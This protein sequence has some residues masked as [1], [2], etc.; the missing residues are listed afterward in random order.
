M[1]AIYLWLL[2]EQVYMPPTYHR[3]HFDFRRRRNEIVQLVGDGDDALPI[4]QDLRVSRLIA[5]QGGSFSYRLVRHRTVPMSSCV[6]DRSAAEVPSSAVVT[7]GI[8]AA[9]SISVEVLEDD[10]DVMI[11][12]TVMIDDANIRKWESEHGHH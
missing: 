7:V 5:D 8:Q 2:P 6:R 12:E 11:V 3:A 10:T 1:H 4:P 9:D